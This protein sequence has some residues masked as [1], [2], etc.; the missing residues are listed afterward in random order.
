ML[1]G[2][3]RIWLIDEKMLSA[4]VATLLSLKPVARLSV[5]VPVN[6]SQS[7]EGWKQRREKSNVQVNIVQ[8]T[9]SVLQRPQLAFEPTGYN[10]IHNLE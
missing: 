2:T 4:V 3:G 9:E 10:D 6:G 1:N 7:C 5:S 8:S